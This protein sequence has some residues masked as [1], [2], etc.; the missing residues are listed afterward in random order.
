L[1][2]GHEDV[3][4][5]TKPEP[6]SFYSQ[7]KAWGEMRLPEDDCLI[8]RAR[9]PIGPEPHPRNLITKLVNY[10]YVLDEPNSVVF[11]DD[12]C[13]AIGV[14][15]QNG[16]LGVYNVVNPGPLSAWEIMGFYCELVD[17]NHCCAKVDMDWLRKRE[18]IKDGRSNCTLNIDKLKSAG[19][20]M[21]DAREK[22]RV[23]MEKYAEAAKEV[24]ADSEEASQ[25]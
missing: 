15:V 2:D 11:V 14:L 10:E 13:Q 1:W 25:E 8:I 18:F 16:E 5:D 9:M 12:F 23:T 20:E 4:E 19:V 17:E 21:P 7:T 6:P 24:A 22:I 3:T